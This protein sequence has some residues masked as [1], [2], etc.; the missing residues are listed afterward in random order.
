MDE[1]SEEIYNALK[2]KEILSERLKALETEANE[3][4]NEIPEQF[5]GLEDSEKWNYW[6]GALAVIENVKQLLND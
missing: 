1:I 5:N 4:L 6:Q 2:E 3:R